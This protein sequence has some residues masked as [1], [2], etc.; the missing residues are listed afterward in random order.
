M[1]KIRSDN[2]ILIA[3]IVRKDFKKEGV[4]FIS[5]PNFPLQLG[6]S[7]YKKNEEIKAHFHIENEIKINKIQEIV[8]IKKGKTLVNLYNKEGFNFKSIELTTGDIIFFVEGGHG[9][10]M[11]EETDIIEVKQGPYFG[12]DK[13]K[14]MIE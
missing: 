6:L 14:R 8:Y 10:K 7:N 5:D 3:I 2:G 4:N 1:E 9:F 12:K 13:D 11:I